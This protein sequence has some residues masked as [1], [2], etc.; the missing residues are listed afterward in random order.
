MTLN[1]LDPVVRRAE[2]APRS[3]VPA[4][5]LVVVTSALAAGGAIGARVVLAGVEVTCFDLLILLGV[6]VLAL[7]CTSGVPS[8]ALA[9]FSVCLLMTG[10]ALT[11]PVGGH[12]V[13][14]SAGV[15]VALLVAVLDRT[16]ARAI[17]GGFIVGT[18][19]H[20]LIAIGGYLETRTLNVTPDSWE[21]MIDY[22]TRFEWLVGDPG[23]PPLATTGLLR[24]QGLTGHPN[25]FAALVVLAAIVTLRFVTPLTI[26][27]PLASL[28]VACA[29]MSL[30]RMSLAALALALLF[31]PGGRGMKALRTRLMYACALVAAGAVA[32]DAMRS[33]LLNWGDSENAN[34]R[35]AG[36]SGLLD[37]ATFLPD[38]AVRT[39]HNSLAFMIDVA[40]IVPG[41]LWVLAVAWC[42]VKLV[43]RRRAREQWSTL[44]VI[45]VLLLT[46]D[47][48]QSPTFLLATLATLCVVAVPMESNATSPEVPRRG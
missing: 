13:I 40:G 34:E 15:I 43:P 41:V 21:T 9:V 29:F 39:S 6:A 28:F 35:F 46:E 26:R 25:E 37:G 32:S 1:A 47:R 8:A 7:R 5:L 27:L 33:R 44:V 31:P 12:Y 19:I 24:M 16:W 42:L 3:T 36:T 22:R 4:P 18:V 14:R 20:S 23:E 11:L 2:H 30:S 45:V 17:V 48:I 38:R 10:V